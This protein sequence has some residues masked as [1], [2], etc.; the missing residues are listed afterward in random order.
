MDNEQGKVIDG[1]ARARHWRRSRAKPSADGAGSE[2]HSD[3]PKSI[4]SSLL[5]PAEMFDG[6][7]APTSDRASGSGE[8]SHDLNGGE[9]VSVDRGVDETR[10]QNLFLS[11]DAVVP[12]PGRQQSGRGSLAALIAQR[13]RRAGT[14]VDWHRRPRTASGSRPRRSARIIPRGRTVVLAASLV[15]AIVAVAGVVAG[16]ETRSTP[17]A[18]TSLGTESTATFDRLKAILL[19]SVA[20]PF[21]TQQPASPPRFHRTRPGQGRRAHQP[22]KSHK[23]AAAVAAAPSSRGY[24]PPSASTGVTASSVGSSSGG[25]AS[26]PPPATPSST[27]Q[28]SGASGGG[29]TSAF[30]SSGALGP[31]SSPD[32]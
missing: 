13:L 32:G 25:S 26:T 17:I 5:V 2:A 29:S 8:P 4:A 7:V 20:S 24:T 1:T 31:G 14:R 19:S 22:G 21:A 28:S 11:P 10:H 9:P 23:A 3:A 6:A 16:S 15:A 30:G 12:D 27:A 18:R